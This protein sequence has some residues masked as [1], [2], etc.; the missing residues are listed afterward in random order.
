MD[1]N[2]EYKKYN[3]Y[4]NNSE[5]L[6]YSTRVKKNVDVK[7]NNALKANT[8]NQKINQK[9]N[10]KTNSKSNVKNLNKPV[11]STYL[12]RQINKNAK[13]VKD[14]LKY[15]NKSIENRRKKIV[16]TNSIDISNLSNKELS[17][18]V[19]YIS[20]YKVKNI[21]KYENENIVIVD[22]NAKKFKMSIFS[23]L[24]ILGLLGS[25]LL[26][27]DSNSRILDAREKYEEANTVLREI[28]TKRDNLLLKTS[29]LSNDEEYKLI[30]RNKLGMDYPEKHQKIMVP[31]EKLNYSEIYV[32]ENESE[33]SSNNWL[34]FITNFWRE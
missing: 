8:K 23:W 10:Q 34:S 12:D 15:D 13:Y 4:N 7:K 3:V 5:A 33:N 6:A 22:D 1:K 18:N 11:K 19:V 24:V 21:Q 17:S 27:I 32:N 31:M 20:N 16:L 26:F 9:I 25:F 2:K 29:T 30:A 14:N 28:E